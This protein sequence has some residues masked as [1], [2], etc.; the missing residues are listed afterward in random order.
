MSL[1]AT[2]T[3]AL[4]QSQFLAQSPSLSFSALPGSSRTGERPRCLL[5]QDPQ[6]LE[7]SCILF[8]SLSSLGPLGTH[9]QELP[10]PTALYLGFPFSLSLSLSVSLSIYVFPVEEKTTLR[11]KEK[12]EG[13][14]K[15]NSLWRVPLLCQLLQS[16]ARSQTSG[17][18]GWLRG[19]RV[20]LR[21]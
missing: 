9:L 19:T 14:V 11:I 16:P 13:K 18:P 21:S 4:S 8:K 17:S 5:Q 7:G 12:V 3:K 15:R 10:H 1:S 2:V 6:L 20:W